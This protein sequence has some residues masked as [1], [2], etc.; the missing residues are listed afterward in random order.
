MH[1]EQSMT[2]HLEGRILAGHLGEILVPDHLE[3]NILVGHLE[4]NIMLDH[5]NQ[6]FVTVP[7]RTL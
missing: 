6:D 1:Q 3:G 4:E 7:R 5:I 2:V